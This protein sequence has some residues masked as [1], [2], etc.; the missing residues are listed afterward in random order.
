[1]KTF[2]IEVELNY[3]LQITNSQVSFQMNSNNIHVDH[4]GVCIFNESPWQILMGAICK[5][6]WIVDVKHI[7]PNL[8]VQID[9]YI[10]SSF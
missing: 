4:N 10:A 1:M 5:Q 9:P 8:S 7:G 2:R 6:F 3:E